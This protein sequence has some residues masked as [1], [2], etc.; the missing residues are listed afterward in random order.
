MGRPRYGARGGLR[1]SQARPP[2]ITGVAGSDVTVTDIRH[3][4]VIKH[5]WSFLVSDE[6]GVVPADDHRGLDGVAR[7]TTLRFTPQPADLADGEARFEID[8][9][10][11]QESE[12]I[13]EIVPQVGD[14]P[15]PRRTLRE[16]HEA[17]KREYSQWTKRCTRF[18]TSNVQLSHFIERSVLDMKMLLTPD[19]DGMP[20]IDAGVPWYSA[21]FGRDALIT[22]YQALAVNPDL[23]WQVLRKLAAFQGKKEDPSREE[24]PGK[25]LHELRVGEMAGAG[26]IPHTPYYGSI[27]STPLWLMVLASTY[28]WT[29]D[30]QSLS[31]LW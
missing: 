4:Q 18:R 3:T 9:E 31:E 15:P 27:D 24:E 19:E 6:N 17:L 29:A 22:A 16:T 1:P 25:I 2:R 23:S 26:E 28:S 14:E 21:L 7:S 12:I 30:H 10:P 8:L 13:V 5:G 11:G 20:F